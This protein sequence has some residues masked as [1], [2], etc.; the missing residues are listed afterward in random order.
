M[1]K[2][3][4]L[5]FLIF[6][7]IFTT[8]C[9]EITAQKILAEE[10]FNLARVKS[11]L[12]KGKF[13]NIELNGTA[14][15]NLKMEGYIKGSGDPDKYEIKY[16]ERDGH[17][18]VWIESPSSVWGNIQ[19]LLRFEIPGNV[20]LEVDNSSG[21]LSIYKVTTDRIN[22][23]TSSGNIETE[24]TKAEL[25][26]RCSSGNVTVED[27]FGELWVTTTSGNIKIKDL[28]GDA[29]FNATSGNINLDN[30]A[31][32]IFARCSSGNI[33]MDRINGKLNTE[34]SSGNIKGDE[35]MLQG[36]SEFRATSGNIRIDLLNPED[37]LSFNLEAG[38][39][40]LRAA[41]N[42][43]EDNMI[44]KRGDI[45]IRGISSSGNQT[46]ITR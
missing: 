37:D 46:Y 38:S 17:V 12:V 21:N 22:L 27:Q 43:G 19:S 26:I 24:D 11:L 8:S 3:S 7:L 39:G 5:Y 1:K 2:H 34:T 4:D 25:R 16:E 20:R 44:I 42:S 18:E 9:T 30:V 6:F 23:K 28:T 14:G 15:S 41:E 40:N 31:G 10:S 13:C 45:S 32:S 36:D 33:T 35:I 29:E